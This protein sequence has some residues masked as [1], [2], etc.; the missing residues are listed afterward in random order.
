MEQ[1]E[2]FIADVMRQTAT[3]TELCSQ[4]GISRKTAYKWLSRYRELG[5]EGLRE[6]PRRP[7]RSPAAVDGPVVEA[8]LQARRRHPDWGPDRLLRLLRNKHPDWAFPSRSTVANLIRRHGLVAE[9]PSRRRATQS[10]DRPNDRWV[11]VLL[12][13]FA[14][15]DRSWCNPLLVSDAFSRYVLAYE[16][17]A[18]ATVGDAIDAFDHLFREYGLPVRIRV[19]RCPPFGANTVAG[20]TELSVSWVR[21][22]VLPELVDPVGLLYSRHFARLQDALENDNRRQPA[23]NLWLQ[24]RRFNRERA[25]R[26][27][28]LSPHPEYRPSLRRLPG[29]VERMEYP[30]HYE[31][32]LVSANGGIR[33]NSRWVNVSTLL[34]GDFVGLE[35]FDNGL[36]NVYY[37]VYP[38]GR[39]DERHMKIQ[40]A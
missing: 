40:R 27:D 8:I 25:A 22:G 21:M 3:I 33:W 26:N 23:D 2:Q 38:L 24:Q 39:L 30:T 9:R 5:A 36:W 28:D 29:A 17:M 7:H 4:Y 6:Q 20:L 35:E 10:F 13:P 1:K 19:P 32:R 12:H 11:A 37:G 18:G 34:A 16:A 31:V 15:N 14:L